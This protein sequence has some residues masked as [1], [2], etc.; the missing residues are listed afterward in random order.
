MA[1]NESVISNGKPTL[2]ILD[3]VDGVVETESNG[4][5]EVLHYIETGDIPGETRRTRPVKQ[6]HKDKGKVMNLYIKRPVLFICNDPYTKGLKE[7]RLKAR[8]LNFGRIKTDKLLEALRRICIAE[9]VT[10]GNEDLLRII[11]INQNDVR[12]SLSML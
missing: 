3:E 2:I 9:K 1:N 6:Q 12:S 11:E 10:L 7:L 8:V 5:K 4:I